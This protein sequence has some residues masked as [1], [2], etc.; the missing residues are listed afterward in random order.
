MMTIYEFCNRESDRDVERR[1]RDIIGTWNFEDLPKGI[2]AEKQAQYLKI[3]IDRN[4]WEGIDGWDFYSDK[5]I[6]NKIR[7]RDR[8]YTLIKY[9]PSNE[10]SNVDV[11][12]IG[13]DYIARWFAED[14]N[15]D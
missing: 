13:Y 6:P 8:D 2:R 14:H 4:V 3:T 7:N 11:M 12:T 5:Y 10:G 9:F 1:I 15:N